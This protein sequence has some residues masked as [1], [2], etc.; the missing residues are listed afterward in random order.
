MPSFSSILEASVHWATVAPDDRAYLF[1]ADRGSPQAELTFS[2]LHHRAL[3]VATALRAQSAQ[4]GDR[5][6]L[7]FPP[8]LEFLVGFFGCLFAGI[9]AVPMMPPR[10]VA[11][12]DASTAIIAD[13]RPRFA[14]STEKFVLASRTDLADRPELT[15]VT[16]VIVDVNG[17]TASGNTPGGSRIDSGALAFLQYTSGSTS[18]PKGVMV[19]HDNLV[20]NLEMIKGVFE[21][22]RES[23]YV[24][25]VPLHHD[26]GLILNC[27]EALYVGAACILMPP[28]LFLQR[29]LSWLRAISDYH[30]RVAGG[31]N[32]AFEHSLARFQPEQM[33]GIDLS[34][35]Q[36]AFNAAEPI[37]A[38]TLTRFASTFAPYGFDPK[39]L[40]PC[41]GMAETTVLVSGGTRG[42]GSVVRSV[43]Q[44]AMK[45]LRVSDAADAA[46]ETRIVGCG[47]AVGEE[48][49][50]I[51]DPESRRR[52]NAD[53]VGEIW[54]SGPNVGRG[55]WQNEQATA[56]TFFA[57][58]AEELSGPWLRTGD[59]GFVD[60]TGELFVT[61]RIKDIIIVRG[62]NY[63][64]Q[65]IEQAVQ[66]AS[67]VFRPGHGAAFSIL[68][69][70][71]NE[72]VIIVQEIERTQRRN[73]DPD[74]LRATVREAVVERHD[75]FLHDIVLLKPGSIPK[76]TSGKVQRRLTRQLWQ[77][78]QLDEDIIATDL[79]AQPRPQVAG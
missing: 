27:L 11:L 45:T 76:T 7:I 61:G 50:A 60:N 40:H 69:S 12:R 43:S 18:T 62:I 44:K 48:R 34:S 42:A 72:K 31:P 33:Q 57:R 51:V 29:P 46:D 13:C 74:E 6:L 37:R 32:F 64:P 68:D 38:D 39:A 16:W 79:G 3:A 35:W 17:S 58:I 54:V 59:L 52:L 75:L 41:Y 65:D 67:P 20:C 47:H 19:D 4:P 71:G 49:I 63:Y 2:A 15:D 8:G 9:I 28:T 1:L 14:L 73:I 66:S 70:K 5:A 55:Y 53:E 21:N 36:V 26:M 24:S 22:T 23:T 78:G 10:R 56:E 77:A 30:A 25:W